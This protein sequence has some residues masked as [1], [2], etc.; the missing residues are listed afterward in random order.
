MTWKEIPISK[1]D[2]STYPN[3]YRRN[4]IFSTVVDGHVFYSDNSVGYFDV[5]YEKIDDG[6]WLMAIEIYSKSDNHY[7]VRPKKAKADYFSINIFSSQKHKQRA[8]NQGLVGSGN[9]VRFMAPGMG[10]D[11]YQPEGTILKVC[12]LIFSHEYLG[13][14]VYSDKKTKSE[15]EIVSLSEFY[16]AI[17]ITRKAA[18]VEILIQSRLLNVLRHERGKHYYKSSIYSD[19]FQLATFFLNFRCERKWGYLPGNIAKTLS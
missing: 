1:I 15:D 14:L 18:S 17:N 10:F 3:F 7:V 16:N 19:F 11:C 13:K 2:P 6:C 12:R 4:S 5:F 8:E 9:L